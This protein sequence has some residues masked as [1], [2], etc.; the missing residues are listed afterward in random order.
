MA[1]FINTGFILNGIQQPKG[2]HCDEIGQYPY[3][4][5]GKFVISYKTLYE[6]TVNKD[7]P[8]TFIHPSGIQ[9]RM[10]NHFVSDRMSNPKFTQWIWEPARFIGPLFHDSGYCFGGLWV[11]C[12][13]GKNFRFEKMTR[14][15]VDNLLAVM[16]KHDPYPGSYLSIAAIWLGV[17]AGGWTGW[18]KGDSRRPKL[19]NT[20]DITKPPI[21]FA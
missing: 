12:D 9:Y 16:I 2:F 11:S 17:R 6:I 13:N 20:I 4:H 15:Q 1:E 18:K 8:V 5:I 14:F 10:D 3:I 19:T 21:A 7:C